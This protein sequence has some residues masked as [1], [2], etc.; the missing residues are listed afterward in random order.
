MK[1]K[2]KYFF[3]L[4]ILLLCCLVAS[5]GCG[6]GGG[7]G[8]K[9]NEQE[10]ENNTSND[11]TP[12]VPDNP[13]DPDSPVNPIDP[14][15]PI[16]PDEPVSDDEHLISPDAAIFSVVFIDIDGSEIEVQLVSEK[17]QAVEPKAP[18]KEGYVFICWLDADGYRYDF[19]SPVYCEWLGTNELDLKNFDVDEMNLSLKDSMIELEEFYEDD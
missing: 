7:S 9:R 14:V 15:E 17:A 12:N 19:D 6:D 18:E 16:V 3:L 13:D 1:L 4:T 11:K 2:Q 5:G 8:E 10:Y